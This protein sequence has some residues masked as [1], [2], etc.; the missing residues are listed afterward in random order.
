M[1]LYFIHQKSNAKINQQN[2]ESSGSLPR[3][4][5]QVMG[6]MET[7]IDFVAHPVWTPQDQHRGKDDECSLFIPFG[8]HLPI[9]AQQTRFVMWFL[10]RVR[11]KCPMSLSWLVRNELHSFPP[12]SVQV[13][14]Q[15]S[16]WSK[17]SQGLAWGGGSFLE[18]LFG[19]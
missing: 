4:L 1:L 8:P 9:A 15:T 18:S 10:F 11:S 6:R 3:L 2:M 16:A 19:H 14:G 5:Q 13:W 7:G 12:P 17:Q